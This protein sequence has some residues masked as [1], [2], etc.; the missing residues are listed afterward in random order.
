MN[1]ALV[2]QRPADAARQLFLLFH[3]VGAAPQHMAPLAQRLAQAFPQAAVVCVAAP[4]EADGGPGR[5]W[6]SVQGVNEDNRP[7]RV[8]DAMPAFV[9]TVRAWQ[10]ETGVGPAATALVGFSQGA[11]MALEST[12][13]DGVLAGRVAALA[14]RFAQLPERAPAHLTWHFIHGKVDPVIHYGH[15]V[16]AAERLIR[17]GGDVTADIIPFLGHGTNDEVETLLIERLTTHVPARVWQE[18]MTHAN[19][20]T[21]S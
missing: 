3:G 17:L 19:P 6:F 12:Q 7:Q 14:G 10:A 1:E 21:S 16:T 2:V 18:A 4:H 15:T 20:S 8:A 5:Q 9:Q 11:I 13:L